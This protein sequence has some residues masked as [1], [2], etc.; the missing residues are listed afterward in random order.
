MSRLALLLI[1]GVVCACSRDDTSIEVCSRPGDDCRTF[2]SWQDYDAWEASEYRKQR[3]RAERFPHDYRDIAIAVLKLRLKDNDSEFANHRPRY[4]V[5]VLG[6]DIDE[7][8]RAKLL[9]LG[10]ATEP[11][12]AFIRGTRQYLESDGE[13]RISNTEVRISSVEWRR[14]GTY[15]VEIDYFCGDLCAGAYRYQVKKDRGKWILIARQALW[16]S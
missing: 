5:S 7:A 13:F 8:S 4:F 2:R 9:A 1:V 12:S 6:E 10:V 3:E 11:G 14:D 15:L 16:F